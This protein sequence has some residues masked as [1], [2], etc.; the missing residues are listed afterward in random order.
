MPLS[1]LENFLIN[2]DGNILYVNPSDLDA[3]DSFDNKGNSLTRPFKTIQRALIEAARFAYQ[4]GDNNDRFDRTTILLYPGIHLLD[5]RQG[6]QVGLISGAVKYFDQNNA[7][8]TSVT[9]LTLNAN[10]VLDIENGGNILYKFNS[11]DGGVIVPKGTSIVGLDLRKTKVKPLYVPDPEDVTV[12]RAALFRITG[13]CYFWQFSMFDADRE[14][15]FNKSYSTKKSPAF[16][17]HK[18]TCFEYADGV[19]SRLAPNSEQEYTDLQMYYF[20]LMNA[21]G[22]N[23]GNRNITDFPTADDFQ[24]NSAEFKIVGDLSANDFNVTELRAD[25][26]AAPK[27]ATV[28][29]DVAHKLSRDDAFRI[30]GVG[31]SALYEGSYRVAGINSERQFTYILPSDPNQ[32]SINIQ[33]TE[34]I[35][36]EA[37]NVNGASPYIFNCSL[38]STFGMC[39]LHADGSKATGFKSMVVAQFTGIGLQK[40]PNAFLIY[41]P[42][43]GEY[44]NN[45]TAPATEVTP[46]YINQNAVYSPAYES[47]HV[48]ASNDSVIQA[49]SVFAIGFAEHFLAEDGADQSITNSNSNFG[50]KSLIAKGFRKQSFN[51]DDTGYVTHIVPPKDL[52][53]QTID[54]NWR[55]LDPV[56]SVGV[57][58]TSRLYLFGETDETNPPSNVTDGYKVGANF[59]EELYLDVVADP[60]T[61]ITSTFSAP[62]LMQVASGDGPRGKKS[63]VVSRTNGI[64]DITASSD[65]IKL[66]ADHNF[67]SGESVRVFSDNARLPDGIEENVKY[68]V[69][70]TGNADEIKLASTLNNAI[71]STPIPVGIK[72]NKGGILTVESRVTDKIPGDAGHPIQFDAT[73]GQ[74]F[75]TTTEVIGNNDIYD[76]F[77]GF[78][79]VI[80]ANNAATYI[81]RTPENRD[82][83][84]RVYK[85]RYVIPREFQ[86]AKAP[87]KNY[88][89]QESK[90]AGEDIFIPISPPPTSPDPVTD[91]QTNRNPRVIA[92]TERAAATVTVTTQQEHKINV[93]DRVRLKNVVSTAN[94]TGKD[95]VSYNGY[96]RVDTVPS[97]TEFTLTNTNLAGT[98]DFTDNIDTIRTGG[99]L[100]KLPVFE[101]N[102]YKTT[103]TIQEVEEIQEYKDGVQ[104][105]VYYLTVLRSDITPV[106]DD[107]STNPFSVRQYKQDFQGLY[108][109]V[110]RDNSVVDP[111]HSTTAASN[112]LLGKVVVDNPQNSISKEAV[113][114]F[115]KDTGIGGKVVLAVGVTG[116]GNNEVDYYFD[117][118]HGLFSLTAVSQV[119]DGAGYGSN[120]DKLYNVKLN[121][122]KGDMFGVDATANAVVGAGG[123]ITSLEIVSGGS[124]YRTGAGM[125]VT[126]AGGTATNLASFQIDNVTHEESENSIQI[127]GVGTAGNRKT[128][129]YNGVYRFTAP[130]SSGANNGF[131]SNQLRVLEGNP[132]AGVHTTSD[133]IAILGG[134]VSSVNSVVGVAG[135]TLPGIVTVNV[136]GSDQH[137]LSVGNRF[138]FYVGSTDAATLA[139]YNNKDF[140]VRAVN[141]PQQF[142]INVDPAIPPV[143]GVGLTILPYAVGA[144]GRDTSLQT[145]KVGGTMN[146]FTGKYISDVLLDINNTQTVIRVDSGQTTT[147]S[148]INSINRGDYIQINNELMRVRAKSANLGG[149]IE[150]TVLR[151]V[152][153]TTTTTHVTGSIVRSI[154]IIPSEVR[155]FSSIRASG[156]TFEYVGYGPGNYST[157][158]PQRIQRTLTNEEELLSVYCEKKGGVT[159][160]SGMNDR[161]E[162]FTLDGRQK[163]VERYIS[164]ATEGLITGTFDDL[165]VRNTISVG[166][167]PNRNFP[168]EFRGPVNFTNKITNTDSD[169][170]IT[171]I[172]LQLKGNS[173]S[174]PSFQVGT[175]ANPSLI[176][177]KDT[178]NVG[179]KTANP[180]FELDVNGT[181]RAE[182]GYRNFKLTDLPDKT[183]E[184]TYERNRILKVNDAANGYELVDIN[185]LPLFRLTSYGVSN[186]AVVHV[187]TGSTV[188]TNQMQIT[189]VSTATF[190][191]GQKVKIFGAGSYSAP[192]TVANP[193]AASVEKQGTAADTKNYRY[194][195]AQFNRR[196]GDIS[197]PV[198]ADGKSNFTNGLNNADIDLFNDLNY[199]SLTLSITDDAF[200][201]LVY[202]Q[203]QTIG[204]NVAANINLAKLIAILGP[205]ETE[206]AGQSFTFNDYGPFNKTAWSKNNDSNEYD[207][208]QIHFPL[209]AA[210]GKRKG[211]GMDEIV[212]IGTSSIVVNNQYEF[213]DKVGFSS[214]RVLKV[215]HDNTHA[216]KLAIDDIVAKGGSYLE[217]PSGT[218]LTQKIDVPTNFTIT[219]VGKNS[220]LKQ[221]FFANDTTDGA[222]NSLSD[223]NI[224]VG[225]GTTNATDVTLSN[226]TIDGNSSNQY[227]FDDIGDSAIL[228]ADCMVDM[229]GV[230]NG[231]FKSIELRNSIMNGMSVKY[232][233]RISIENSAFVDGSPTDEF[234]YTPLRATESESLRIN[235]CLFENYPGA[236]DVSSSS[237]V[238]TGGNIIRNCGRGLITFATGKISTTDNIILGPADEFIPSPD[239]FDS[240]FNGVNITV[241]TGMTFEGPVLQYIEEGSPKDISDTA[242]TITA[243]IG[244]IVG[245]ASTMIPERM[246]PK[247]MDFDPITESEDSEFSRQNGYIQLKLNTSKTTQLADLTT[248]GFNNNDQLA[249]TVVGVEF[250]DVPIGLSTNI[251]ISTAAW[252]KN[253]SAFI[254][255]GA[256]EYRV[257]LKDSNQYAGITTGDIVKLVDHSSNPDIT[258]TELTVTNK[259]ENGL[260]RVITLAGLNVTSV[261]NGGENAD[262][263]QNGYISI[264]KQFVI[265]KGRV[266]VI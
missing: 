98:D 227:R 233:R 228:Q 224:F 147:G 187:G 132:T 266:G 130:G 145:E 261:T 9:D 158:L 66:T 152:M 72:N 77:V 118:P 194:W 1:R 38:R 182:G 157:A 127:I 134:K 39:G 160:F 205:K 2:T 71:A 11:I 97:T 259:A 56:K 258:T 176:V 101:R 197:D 13:G 146:S 260:L 92:K 131:L 12:D 207:E 100:S 89:L 129:A 35:V 179:I 242:V 243:G 121:N 43:S 159:Y 163:P 241:Q 37:D 23:T 239:I 75:I 139:A 200:G 178:Q 144:Q 206:V 252:F 120:G 109:S 21:Y 106:Q 165:Y 74:W 230:T 192:V 193:G 168:S 247:F 87:T 70:T 208:D 188:N 236:V 83:N 15:F 30:V 141:S 167:G 95:D 162:F 26:P 45:T 150:L 40:D 245:A 253:D 221:Q 201:I 54:V 225:I 32:D 115:V 222:G 133:G 96:F 107:G 25:N 143:L 17:H 68:F 114:E 265:A 209:T 256:T 123:S 53:E 4:V 94:T 64:N 231:L 217:L 190:S 234:Q 210:N 219:G 104:D 80:S 42:T 153:G 189:G 81:R 173:N 79:T 60:N 203:I 59:N 18:L 140:I 47:F 251:G 7:D 149:Y 111:V 151:G 52:Q 28:T 34:K 113:L 119:H 122:G 138:R 170:G 229:S 177:K 212:S 3:T 36:I 137:G 84:D 235:D 249:Y 16:S 183:L 155:R 46:L 22:T 164:E 154:H 5:N 148:T 198:P 14:V 199:N 211:W 73:E 255:A 169:D 185:V 116:G 55:A 204:D 102:E 86:N 240:D 186:D 161:G 10:S 6:L 244:T 257:T 175:D 58:E 93:G 50:A 33:N 125:T 262:G 237:V 67:F 248:F 181:I 142:T 213:N 214:N 195:T 126:L 31:G 108:P 76:S 171:A 202:R 19:N 136:A 24:P 63:F 124:N 156:H 110:D 85:L 238:A 69:I 135:T 191:V 226:F 82:V 223:N 218:F 246:G 8:K 78:S 180:Q 128:S 91:I 20:K 41:D 88:V 29:T 27:E 61:G 117:K 99:D 112:A 220:V 172:K 250:Q 49:V 254:G 65:T 174:K 44:K 48:K 184:P 264:R 103:Y 216:F 90:D 57:G 166:G 215:V 105:G 62:I 196:T 232:G 51:R 263:S